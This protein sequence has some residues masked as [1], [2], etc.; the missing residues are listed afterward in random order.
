ML[1]AFMYANLVVSMAQVDGAKNSSL[2][3]VVKQVCNMGNQEYIELCLIVLATVINTHPQFTHFLAN[4][5]NWST[6]G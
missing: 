4:K 1:V 6:I 2:S 5:E 3:Q